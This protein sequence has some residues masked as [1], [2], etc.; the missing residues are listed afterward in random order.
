MAEKSL[1]GEEKSPPYCPTPN[2]PEAIPV[3]PFHRV[4]WM[5]AP[6]AKQH[7]D[8]AFIIL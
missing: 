7:F 1:K 4:F 5:V 2:F 8:I 3:H 6:V